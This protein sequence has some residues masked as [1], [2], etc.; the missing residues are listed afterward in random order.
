[1]VIGPNVSRI[2]PILLAILFLNTT[3]L[4]SRPSLYQTPQDPRPEITAI[5][6][7]ALIDGSGRP[8]IKDSVVVIQGDSIV[9]VGKNKCPHVTWF[10]LG[11]SL[12][13]LNA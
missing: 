13:Y 4:N 1:M 11:F 3:Q 12:S 5:V 7:A 6:G 9:D 10:S 2:A 8:A